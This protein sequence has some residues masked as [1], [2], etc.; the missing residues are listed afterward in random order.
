VKCAPRVLGGVSCIKGFLHIF[1]S[2]FRDLGK[3][4]AVD[5]AMVGEVFPMDGR[6]PTSANE[7]FIFLAST[8]LV[9]GIEGM[10]NSESDATSAVGMSNVSFCEHLPNL[11]SL[12]VIRE[13]VWEGAFAQA[14]PRD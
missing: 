3:R 13:G 6:D 10:V 2:R 8:A 5:R 7:V 12:A 1:R 4:L 9:N 11:V 14:V